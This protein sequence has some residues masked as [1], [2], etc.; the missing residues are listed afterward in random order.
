M[1]Q[2]LN[3]HDHWQ[4]EVW[5]RHKNDTIY[6]EWLKIS[7]MRD[8]TGNISHYVGVFSDI[9]QLKKHENQLAFLAYHDPL[10]RLGNRTLFEQQLNKA[11]QRAERYQHNLGL[12]FID[13]NGFKTV[14][15]SLGHSMGDRL[16]QAVA[17]RLQAHIR[18]CD[19]LSRIGGDEFTILLHELSK[20]Q[21]ASIVA[22]KVLDTLAAPFQI[23]RNMFYISASIGIS[24]YPTDGKDADTLLKNADIAM[25]RAKTIQGGCFMFYSADMGRQANERL[26]VINDL[27]LALQRQEFILHYQPRLNLTTQFIPGVEALIRWQHP[28][29]GMVPPDLF[30][31]LA[32]ETGL[33]A[34]IGEW[35]FKTACEQVKRW[36][37]AGFEWLCV[38]VN[39]SA[40]QLRQP[41]LLQRLSDILAETGVGADFIELEITETAAMH[42]PVE[43]S[44]LLNQLKAMGFDIAID[45]FGT[46]YSSLSYLKRFPIDYLKIDRAFIKDLPDSKEDIAIC[47]AI[48]A[49]AESMNLH[50]I[51][52]GVETAEQQEFLKHVNC[53]DIQGYLI[54]RPVPAAELEKFLID[55]Q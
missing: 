7:A 54:S 2:A 28:E 21:A 18:V 38:A 25:Y 53:H 52:E 9:T 8:T 26:A 3:T 15:D 40:A 47:E 14:N 22:Q 39:L 48:I 11:I 50:V 10:T 13:L 17:Q 37:N 4:G 20:P 36:H 12:L 32:E 34:D 16:L 46:G 6:P 41:T 31:P 42:D 5:N 24:Y 43:T 27:R 51:A 55:R 35:V 19:D 45:D 23:E 33:I 30:I 1:W 49:L 29:R 44:R